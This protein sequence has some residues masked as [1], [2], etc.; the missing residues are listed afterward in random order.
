MNGD[1]LISHKLDNKKE[2]NKDTIPISEATKTT[3]EQIDALVS[4][5]GY[6][7]KNIN[8][9]TG[10]VTEYEQ[11]AS[12]KKEEID[13]EIISLNA[14]I[15]FSKTDAETQ[16][17]EKITDLNEKSIENQKLYND[18]VISASEKLESSINIFENRISTVKNVSKSIFK[19]YL[20]SLVILAL[21]TVLSVFVCT[22]TDVPNDY[23]IFLL[24]FSQLSIMI[25]LLL[26]I[27][28]LST[29]NNIETKVELNDL[30]GNKKS[31]KE[32]QIPEIDTN[33]SIEKRGTLQSHINTTK[34]I[35]NSFLLIAGESIPLIKSVYTEINL[36]VKYEQLVNN[37]VSAMDYYNIAVNVNYF[38]KVT[39]QVPADIRLMD[40]EDYWKNSIAEKISKNIEQ[41]NIEASKE[42]I[43]LLYGEHNGF[44]TKSLFWKISGLEYEFESLSQILISSGKLVEMG[45]FN[46]Y[47]SKDIT[48]V[49]KANDNFNISEIN[50]LLSKSIRL[51]SYLFSYVEF[52][53]NNNIQVNTYPDIPFVVNETKNS[54]DKFENQIIRLSYKIGKIALSSYYSGEFLDGF[55]RASISLKYHDEML[56]REISCKC[57]GNNHSTAIIKTY[58]EKY[59][60]NNGQSLISLYDLITNIDQIKANLEK[61]NEKDFIHLR[62]HLKEGRW[63]DNTMSLM[64]DL[65][66]EQHEET[67]ELLSKAHNYQL[68]IKIIKETF[69]NV[70]IGT[71]DKAIDS[72]IF[73]AYIIMI[74]KGYGNLL[75]L[76]D[77][78]SKLDIEKS[79]QDRIRKKTQ[80]VISK[81]YI[82]YKIRPKYDFVAFADNAR[83]GILKEGQSFLDFQDEF[84]KDMERILLEAKPNLK[85]GLIIQRIS[86]SKYS[87]GILDDNNLPGSINL[88]NLDI[89]KY[90]TQLVGDYVPVE[91]QMV[92]S[93][94]DRDINLFEVIKNKKISELL[95]QENDNLDGIEI[96]ALDSH[97]FHETF[98]K[99]ITM[100]GSDDIVS[101]SLDL[102]NG[103]IEKEDVRL[104]FQ[105]IISNLYSN[106][107]GLKN[108]SKKRSTIITN[109]LCS[110]LE[111][112]G[113]LCNWYL[114]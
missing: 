112:L 106:T 68:L 69:T 79:N 6:D 84:L 12:T 70:N 104:V 22:Y 98:I 34:D 42:I 38:N 102:Y 7:V 111:D 97:N 37:F 54:D 11:L 23:I 32:L 74:K 63:F 89:A 77:V 65:M 40:T 109:R 110:V 56:L 67:K 105:N 73:G 76:V 50:N 10:I 5:I 59:K 87:F 82:L 66:K 103:D 20:V 100:L 15:D 55:V 2:D 43:L 90:I 30:S 53:A 101:L 21:V 81:N 107:E 13:S 18:Q 88:K 9:I 93:G 60:E 25:S 14:A 72:Q 47:T 75:P 27:I 35:L 95:R 71:V 57:S 49:L 3:Q 26:S 4:K 83:I 94:L 52:L 114:N 28:E 96:N 78:L 85:S 31:L 1:E 91:K 61:S 92:I 36:L 8:D 113:L 48:S 58:H 17:K 86:P 80:K 33:I 108:K 19:K 62:T 46:T 44:D 64:I 39:G 41:E 24:L 29:K 45:N 16:I 51:S 99:E